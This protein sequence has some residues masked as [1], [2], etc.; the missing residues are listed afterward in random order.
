MR[1]WLSLGL[2]CLLFVLATG[3]TAAKGTETI[4]FP[5]PVLERKVRETIGKPVG[6]ITPGDVEDVDNL[7]VG[8]QTKEGLAAEELVSDLSGLEYFANLYCL[9]AYNNNITDISPLSCLKS[10]RILDLGGNAVTDL[11]PLSGLE[12]NELYLWGNGVTDVTPLAEV[13]GLTFLYLDENL[14]ADV[15]PLAGLTGLKR[16]G[17]SSTSSTCV[18]WTWAATVF[19]TSER[20]HR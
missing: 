8:R 14:I 3:A 17:L 11:S 15:S 6:D 7:N 12:I 1:K 5:D 20:C 19:P 9:A 13:T 16:L 18:S 4:V 2:A 10:L